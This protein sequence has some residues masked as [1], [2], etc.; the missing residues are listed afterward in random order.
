MALPPPAGLAPPG[1]GSNLSRRQKAAIVVRLL[2]AE[3]AHLRLDALPEAM[4]EDLTRQMAGIRMVDRD[5]LAAVIEEFLQELEQVGLSFPGGMAGALDLLDGAL[6]PGMMAR[7]RRQ[8]GPVAAGDPWARIAEIDAA[9]LLPVLEAESIEVGAVLLSKL[10]VGKAAELLGQLPGERARRMSYAISLTGSIAPDA[11][12]RIGRA[13]AAQLDARPEAAF[14]TGPV[15]RVG[16]ILNAAPAATRDE[17]LEGLEEADSG[18]AEMVRR[19]IFTFANIPTRIDPRD[20]PRIVRDVDQEVLITA[21]AGATGPDK[22]ATEFIL[23]NMSQRMA[24]SLREEIAEAGKVKQAD[25][26]AAMGAIV[27]AIRALEAEG[28]LFLLAGDE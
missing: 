3:G 21:M 26:E 16:A 4:Q 7:L 11:V 1:R 19:S 9:R 20:V 17:V 27:G 6:D 8:A 22:A 10:G 5:T 28:T 15:E 13:L 25:A 12:L 24:D 14:D 2:L 18:F 23:S